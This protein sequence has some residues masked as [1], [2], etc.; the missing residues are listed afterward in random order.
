MRLP[1][2]TLKLVAVLAA[3][4]P[5]ARLA[6]QQQTA[7]QNGAPAKTTA[8]ISGVVVDSLHSRYLAG[9]EVIIE[10]VKGSLVTDSA[11]NFKVDGLPPGTYQIGVFH[12]ILDTLNISLQAGRS[13]WDPTA[14]AL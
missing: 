1:I 9:A 6:A 11:G 7:A 13:M 3:V 8:E 14:R 2:K 4:A 5:F 10:G 12:P